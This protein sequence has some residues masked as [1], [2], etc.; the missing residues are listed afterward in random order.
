MSG[1]NPSE[2]FAFAERET[3]VPMNHALG[4]EIV[5]E[6]QRTAATLAEACREFLA[7]L[8][9]SPRSKWPYAR[10]VETLQQSQS[11]V[12]VYIAPPEVGFSVRLCRR[13]SP[14][15]GLRSLGAGKRPAH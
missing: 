5:G 14:M 11:S 15:G 12:S 3:Q 7:D 2:A 1:K 9:V 13:S 8:H 4:I 10:R 6:D